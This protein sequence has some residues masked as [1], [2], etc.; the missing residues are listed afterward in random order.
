MRGNRD[1]G[2]T[3]FNA[4]RV[5]Q[6]RG[7]TSGPNTA[8]TRQVNEMLQEELD[9]GARECQRQGTTVPHWYYG[10]PFKSKS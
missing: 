7:T 5:C 10:T 4:Y 1:E 6:K 2:V 9:R 8:F 3:V